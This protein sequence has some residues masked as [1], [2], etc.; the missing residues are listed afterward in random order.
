VGSQ[1]VAT[2]SEGKSR[3][4]RAS[5]RSVDLKP[6]PEDDKISARVAANT[7]GPLSRTSSFMQ[8]LSSASTKAGIKALI[9][10]ANQL[11]FSGKSA[12]EVLEDYGVNPKLSRPTGKFI[13]QAI[14]KLREDLAATSRST[15]S[16]I[17]VED[18]LPKSVIDLMKTQLKAGAM[19]ANREQFIKVFTQADDRT[20]ENTM[21]KHVLRSLIDRILDAARG[22]ELSKKAAAA[23][24]KIGEKFVP[25]FAKKIDSLAKRDGIKPSD[26]PEHL[27][28]WAEELDSFLSKYRG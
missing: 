2:L 14:E 26:V 23:K 21:M 1:R 19:M 4:I 9:D 6:M 12:D 5:M 25:N 8:C 27:P 7:I 28:N 16:A 18:A 15:E 22:D 11:K 13:E 24:R 3:S 17:A 20:I 10:F